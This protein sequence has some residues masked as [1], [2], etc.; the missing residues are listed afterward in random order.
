MYFFVA[1]FPVDQ[2]LAMLYD[3][4]NTLPKYNIDQQKLWRSRKK[5]NKHGN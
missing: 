5:A 2:E 3:P 4:R 1:Y